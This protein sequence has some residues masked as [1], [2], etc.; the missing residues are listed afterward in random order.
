MK[1]IVILMAA[2]TALLLTSYGRTP[3]ERVEIINKAHEGNAEAQWQVGFMHETS[4]GVTQSKEEAAKWYEKAAE[5]DY[6]PACN[7]LG[8]LY[9][10]GNGVKKDLKKAEKYYLKAIKQEN[11]NAM[12]NLGN[13]YISQKKDKEGLELLEKASSEGMAAAACNIGYYYAHTQKDCAKGLIYYRLAAERGDIVSQYN[14]GIN[15][16]NGLCGLEQDYAEAAKWYMK[17]AD[18]GF[19]DAQFCIGKCYMLGLGVE[20]NEEL[21]LE[22]FERA[23]AQNETSALNQLAYAYAKGKFFKPN[24]AKALSLISKNIEIDPENPNWYDSKGEIYAIFGDYE[25]AKVMYEKVLK[26][27]PK[28]YENN[29]PAVLD[30]IIKGRK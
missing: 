11:V 6:S 24:K 30:D 12:Y 2:M 9:E 25:N 22:W 3:E 20:Q 5:Q 14:L 13:L 18:N 1:R 4:E 8:L 10:N 28:F 19:A 15:F 23:A 21:G 7:N 27:S 26:I 17:S 29:E 16:E